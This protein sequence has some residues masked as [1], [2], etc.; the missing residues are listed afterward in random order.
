MISEEMLFAAS[1]G[2]HARPAGELVKMV[3]S[4]APTKVTLAQGTRTVNAASMLSVLSLGLKGGTHV[5]VSADGEN[6][7]EALRQVVD[8]LAS[9]S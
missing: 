5:V 8:Y 4:L 6:E 7:Q 2:L 3:K 9:L 1:E